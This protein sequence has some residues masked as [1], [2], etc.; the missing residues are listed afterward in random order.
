M[1][2]YRN[3]KLRALDIDFKAPRSGDAGYDL[4]AI[5]DYNVDPGQRALV[6]TGL[7]LEIPPGF[8]GLIKDRSSV[9]SAGIHTLAGV[10]DSAYR[11]ELRILIVNLGG[12][13]LRIGAGQKIAQLLVVPAYTEV[14]EFVDS[15]G[16]LT[17]S[18]R[19]ADGFGSTGE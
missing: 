4:F 11:G 8:V 13:P 9:A 3:A 1:R 16:D 12:S 15:L 5:A 14:I 10:I 6:D 19:G 2:V 17:S 18:E 7:H